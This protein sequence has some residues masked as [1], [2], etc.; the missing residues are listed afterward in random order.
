VAARLNV[1][2]GSTPAELPPPEVVGDL[3]PQTPPRT[4]TCE[5]AAATNVS[6]EGE[7]IVLGVGSPAQRYKLTAAT[8]QTVPPPLFRAEYRVY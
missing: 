7:E 2:D 6:E 4:P 3:N 8:I 5:G 1:C